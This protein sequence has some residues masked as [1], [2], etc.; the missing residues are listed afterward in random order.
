M[1][2]ETYSLCSE[3]LAETL[4]GQNQSA[5]KLQQFRDIAKQ[6]GTDNEGGIEIIFLNE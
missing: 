6:Y 4:N 3:S 2:L 1:L 5:S